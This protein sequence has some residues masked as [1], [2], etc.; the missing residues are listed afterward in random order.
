M[1][2]KTEMNILTLL[3]FSLLSL[4]LEDEAV[5]FTTSESF[6]RVVG[7]EGSYNVN[8]S[9]QIK[10]WQKDGV[11][12]FHKFSSAG[13]LKLFLESGHC[14]AHVVL[15]EE[16]TSV[17][18]LEDYMTDVSDGVWHKIHFFIDQTQARLTISN[19]TVTNTLPSQIR[20]GD[21]RK[22]AVK[23][24]LISYQCSLLTVKDL[25]IY[26]PR[27]I[28]YFSF[29]ACSCNTQGSVN[30]ACDAN[31]VCACKDNYT[32]DKCE[33]CAPGHFNIANTCNRK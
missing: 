10:T 16:G 13:Y 32:G 14:K 29:T 33:D 2:S 12:M 17:T 1:I 25:P 11:V 21:K 26:V 24:K 5:T 31:G 3:S 27:T 23:P 7:Y 19:K 18:T 4:S 8:L 20:T 28:S 9:L 6:V 30:I 15:S 22:G